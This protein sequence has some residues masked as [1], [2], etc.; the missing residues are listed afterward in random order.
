M[1]NSATNAVEQRIAYCSCRNRHCPK[2]QSLARAEWM[3]AGGTSFS[4]RSISCRLHRSQ[5]RLPRLPSECQRGLRDPVPAAAE[6]L[7]TIAADRRHLGAE[8]GFFAVL[9]T[10][11]Q[12]LSYHPAS[13][14]RRHRRRAVAGREPLDCVPSRFLPTRRPC[15]PDSSGDCFSK[16]CKRHLTPASCGFFRHWNG[17]AIPSHSGAIWILP[18]GSIG[19]SMPSHPSPA[20]GGLCQATLRWR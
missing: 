2:C 14:L 17:C 4:I 12:N 8:I 3:E 6:T 19:W 16:L 13:P 15:S 1:S 20:M 11:G 18:A 9:H 7:R 5:K 10:W